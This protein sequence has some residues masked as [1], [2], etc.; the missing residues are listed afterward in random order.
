MVKCPECQVGELVKDDHN[1]EQLDVCPNCGFSITSATAHLVNDHCYYFDSPHKR[2]RLSVASTSSS[3][4]R[5]SQSTSSRS[6][7]ARKSCLAL[8]Q[9]FMGK[10]GVSTKSSVAAEAKAIVEAL[11]MEGRGFKH[12]AVASAAIF[13]AFRS[14]NSDTSLKALIQRLNVD[15]NNTNRV[16]K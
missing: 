15:L 13:I 16:L 12:E 11:P 1:F 7:A 2:L 3:T 14:H 6:S 10:I 9:S 5:L 4:A 8:L